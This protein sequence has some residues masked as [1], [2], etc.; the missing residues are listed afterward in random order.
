MRQPGIP[1]R[2]FRMGIFGLEK[3]MR[4]LR[5]ATFAQQEQKAVNTKLN[6]GRMDYIEFT[7]TDI[8]KIRAFYTETFGWKFTDSDRIT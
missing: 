2:K 1:N 4:T 8:A 7:T 5:E 3:T 6:D